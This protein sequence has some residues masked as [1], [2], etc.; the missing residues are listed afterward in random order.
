MRSEATFPTPNICYGTVKPARV[1]TNAIVIPQRA[2]F[3][4]LA[5][6]YT[7]V[8]GD[9]GIAHQREIVVQSEQDDIYLIKDGL[10][11]NEKI[12]LE[13]IRQVRDG[14]HVQYEFQAAEDVLGNLKYH[15]E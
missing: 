11:V 2:T 3:E 13:G 7:F 4:I 14:E 15:A 5:K 12:V 8:V 6:R 1:V 9:D 10:D